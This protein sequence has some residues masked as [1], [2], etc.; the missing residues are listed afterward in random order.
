MKSIKSAQPAESDVYLVKKVKFKESLLPVVLCVKWLYMERHMSSLDIGNFLQAYEA[1]RQ[2]IWEKDFSMTNHGKAWFIVNKTIWLAPII[3]FVASEQNPMKFA[4]GTSCVSILHFFS[5]S[6]ITLSE[7]SGH[8]STS[9]TWTSTGR[10]S[11]Q[12]IIQM[13]KEVFRRYISG[14]CIT[15]VA[16]FVSWVAHSSLLPLKVIFFQ[17]AIKGSALKSFFFQRPLVCPFM[18]IKSLRNVLKFF[19]T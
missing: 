16:W 7:E 3:E 13:H 17:K 2:A 5:S 10:S 4:R 8:S 6:H 15:L 1:T 18:F 14:F 9:N 12:N 11:L 19:P